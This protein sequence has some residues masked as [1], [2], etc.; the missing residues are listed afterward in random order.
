[1]FNVI[2]TGVGL[3]SRAAKV[4]AK[5]LMWKTEQSD[6]FVVMFFLSLQLEER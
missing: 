4:T 1:M 5:V 3:N 6:S 2:E